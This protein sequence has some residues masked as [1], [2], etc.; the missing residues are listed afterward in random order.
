M[1]HIRG[2]WIIVERN[3]ED[4]SLHPLRKTGKVLRQI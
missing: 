4:H 3:P 2:V 1:P